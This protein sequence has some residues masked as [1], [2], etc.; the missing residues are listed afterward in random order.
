MSGD[1]ALR[2]DALAKFVP[3]ERPKWTPPGK[4]KATGKTAFQPLYFPGNA[5][6]AGKPWSG[7]NRPAPYI[8]PPCRLFASTGACKF[9]VNCKFSHASPPAPAGAP[10]PPPPR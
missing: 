5:K 6:G 10:P 2:I 4:G 3:E 1:P 9:G 7:P 8:R